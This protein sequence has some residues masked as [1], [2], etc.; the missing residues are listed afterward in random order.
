MQIQN[1]VIVITGAAQ[2][3]GQSMAVYLSNLGAKLALVDMNAE[4][5]KQCQAL[6]EQAGSPQVK[7][8]VCNVAIE[9]EVETLFTN[10]P[11]D[12]GGLNGLVNNAG[13]LR[14]GLLI[15]SGKEGLKK[16]SLQQWQS[17]ID[18]NL[19]GVFLCGREFALQAIEHKQQACIINISSI[20]R[21]GNA[22]QS[23]YSAAKAGVASLAVVW[24]KELARYNIR[25]NSIAPGFIKTDMTGEMRPEI[26]E[27]LTQQIPLK[28]MGQADEIA[29]SVAFLLENDYVSGRLIEV[30]GGLRL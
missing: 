7:T 9:A 8:Y 6:C 12:L 2:G 24:A 25:A 15:K 10:I 4:K 20:S 5:L 26:L 22:G 16:M 23:N 18:V 27:H 1:S 11:K 19:T 28:R 13:I 17:V 30:D 14:D 29:H 21:A 3:L